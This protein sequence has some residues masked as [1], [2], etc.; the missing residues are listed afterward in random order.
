MLW[1]NQKCSTPLGLTS[2]RYVYSLFEFKSSI[3]KTFAKLSNWQCRYAICETRNRKY[4][5]SS[6]RK[7]KSL[8]LTMI[9]VPLRS[10]DRR[11]QWLPEKVRLSFIQCYAVGDGRR[12]F[13]VV[14]FVEG[15][16][17]KLLKSKTRLILFNDLLSS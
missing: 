1:R 2:S 8:T 7:T 5:I 3:S 16:S 12:V 13:K 10:I 9:H 11:R 4:F 6:P 14:F 17:F 15:L